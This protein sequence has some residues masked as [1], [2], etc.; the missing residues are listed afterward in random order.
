MFT[1]KDL[2]D[3]VKRRATVDQGGTTFDTAIKNI[4]N[5]SLFRL[6]REAY[7][8]VLRREQTISITTS[9]EEFNLPAQV[10]QRMFMW[11]EDYGYPYLMQ[12][13]PEKEFISYGIDR[14]QT[15][16]PTHY[17]MWSVDM[18]ETQPT[19]ASVITVQSTDSSDTSIGVTIFGIVSG[20]PD[21]EVITTNSSDGTTS[22]AGSKSFTSVERVVKNGSSVG[23][24]TATSNSGAVTVATIPVGDTTA[25]IMYH[26]IK[27]YPQASSSFNMNIYY[28]KQPY[29]LV[30]NGDV[31]ELGQDFDEAL[32]LLACMK[33]KSEQN[34][35]EYQDFRSQYRDEMRS[36]RKTNIDK[37]D[38]IPKLKSEF[39][40]ANNNSLIT[41]YLS[42][43]QVGSQFGPRV[44]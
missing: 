20:Y 9:T 21:Y 23:R 43:R 26:K 40:S 15:G 12:Y 3:E 2:Q 19:S 32:I 14:T 10:T 42:Y 36:L 35:K 5:T 11:H 39:N 16:T 30:N 22:V 25:G 6:A 7:W 44:Y 4:I 29:R 38:W 27:I 1:F 28:Y 18:V 24:I 37:M 34:Q 8:R 13:V 33:L 31:H 17:R 41:P